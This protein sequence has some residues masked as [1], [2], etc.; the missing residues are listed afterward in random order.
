[1]SGVFLIVPCFNP[2][3]DNPKPYVMKIQIVKPGPEFNLWILRIVLV[4]LYVLFYIYKKQ[5]YL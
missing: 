4:T 3:P 5:L 1:M 2:N